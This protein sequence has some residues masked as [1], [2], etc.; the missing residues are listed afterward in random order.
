MGRDHSGEGSWWGGLTVGRAVSEEGSPWGGLTV[1]RAHGGEGSLVPPPSCFCSELTQAKG[2]VA[3]EYQLDAVVE[4][5]TWV[6]GENWTFLLY[7]T[8]SILLENH[9]SVFY[10]LSDPCPLG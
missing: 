4:D 9:V 3:L 1:Q 7:K 2:S 6:A 10:D 8:F 5:H